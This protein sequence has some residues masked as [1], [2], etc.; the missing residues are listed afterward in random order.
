MRMVRGGFRTLRWRAGFI[1]ADERRFVHPGY[2]MLLYPQ[3][4]HG[5][6]ALD[7]N[8]IVFSTVSAP[9]VEFRTTLWR[10]RQPLADI[11]LAR[12]MPAR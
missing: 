9:R 4:L 10:A 3:R 8:R 5:R 2:C 7:A 11:R 6:K 1:V 12:V